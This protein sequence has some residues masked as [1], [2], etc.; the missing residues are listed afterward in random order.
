M[1]LNATTF[2]EEHTAEIQELGF[3]ADDQ[4]SRREYYAE[5]IASNEIQI[6]TKYSLPE[7]AEEWVDFTL[8]DEYFKR[9]TGHEDKIMV[10]KWT[11]IK[12][13]LTYFHIKKIAQLLEDHYFSI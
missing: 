5:I 11:F 4:A 9:A 7:K 2:F 8:P 10:S 1:C 3:R 13:E 12:P 6:P